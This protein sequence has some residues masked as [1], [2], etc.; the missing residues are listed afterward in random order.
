MHAAQRRAGQDKPEPGVEEAVDGAHAQGPDAEARADVERRRRVAAGA[1]SEEQADRLGSQPPPREL[2]CP[3]GGGVEPLDVIDGD[4]N[5]ALARQAAEQPQ[6]R[7]PERPI[8]GG[9]RA[10]RLEQQRDPQRLR[11]RARELADRVL[12]RPVQEVAEPGEVELRLGLGGP[13][14]E[15]HAGRAAAPPPRRPATAW[16]CRS[17]PLP[18]ASS[19]AGPADPC[20]TN[21][22]SSASSRSRPTTSDAVR[23]AMPICRD[24]MARRPP[25]PDYSASRSGFSRYS[26]IFARNSAASAP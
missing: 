4:E 20:S 13:R 3:S 16:S 8:V 11:L 23:A 6:E 14:L 21:A 2:E 22:A 1:P 19:A 17:R 7:D 12:R 15:H 10:R 5:R 18:R 24:R 26:R 25:L 9:A